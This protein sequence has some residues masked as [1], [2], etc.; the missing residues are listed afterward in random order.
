MDTLG[1]ITTEK[2]PYAN[3]F[4]PNWKDFNLIEVQDVPKI[5]IPPYDSDEVSG[6]SGSHS[7]PIPTPVPGYDVVIVTTSISSDNMPQMIKWSDYREAQLTGDWGGDEQVNAKYKISDL[8]GTD[9][10]MKTDAWDKWHAICDYYN[11]H[12]GDTEPTAFFTSLRSALEDKLKPQYGLLGNTA[13][14]IIEHK[15]N[16]F[17]AEC[18]AEF[19]RVNLVTPNQG[20]CVFDYIK[21]ASTDADN[22]TVFVCLTSDTELVINFASD[23][24]FSEAANARSTKSYQ[25]AQS[26]ANKLGTGYQHS[27]KHDGFVGINY[28]GIIIEVPI[29]VLRQNEDK[30]IQAIQEVVE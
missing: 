8:V 20:E 12:K 4:D 30:L 18:E 1:Y 24:A 11:E 29:Q 9:G 6:S 15:A 10:K 26:F 22:H 7:T 17:K 27:I 3:E 2:S 14:D 23:Q 28:M 13:I 5:T 25:I 16:E 19:E 21:R